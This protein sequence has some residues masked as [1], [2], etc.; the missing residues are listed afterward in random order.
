MDSLYNN[1]LNYIN[2]Y[3]ASEMD[4]IC[5]NDPGWSGLCYLSSEKLMIFFTNLFPRKPSA[6]SQ[7]V[8]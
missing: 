4:I 1:I 6:N 2:C 5:Q 7:S 8:I 3:D